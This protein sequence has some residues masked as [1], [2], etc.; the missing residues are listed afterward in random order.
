MDF[1]MATQLLIGIFVA[2]RCSHT[3]R[4][5]AAHCLLFKL[6]CSQH[7]QMDMDRQ[8]F[9]FPFS[10]FDRGQ[11][12]TYSR[13]SLTNSTLAAFPLQRTRSIGLD[14][15]KQGVFTQPPTQEEG[16]DVMACCLHGLQNMKRSKLEDKKTRQEESGSKTHAERSRSVSFQT[17]GLQRWLE[18]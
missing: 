16:A 13:V 12:T 1:N 17:W 6:W 14:L 8:Y 10:L 7:A 3:P 2:S 11:Q 9:Q 4:W 5:R 18:R 15:H